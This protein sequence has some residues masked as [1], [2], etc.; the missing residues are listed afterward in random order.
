MTP[1]GAVA[2]QGG[3]NGLWGT[4]AVGLSINITMVYSGGGGFP[5]SLSTGTWC[6]MYRKHTQKSQ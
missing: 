4:V 3:C 2:V 5:P 6:C 1:A